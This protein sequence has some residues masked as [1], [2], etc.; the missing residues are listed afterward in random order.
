MVSLVMSTLWVVGLDSGS[1]EGH[2]QSRSKRV[3][4]FEAVRGCKDVE[5]FNEFV[6]RYLADH[7][8]SGEVARRTYW[9]L[10]Y[11]WKA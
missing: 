8:L 10:F 2:C 4:P 6:R 11:A 1:S 9:A 3:D 7:R 5:S